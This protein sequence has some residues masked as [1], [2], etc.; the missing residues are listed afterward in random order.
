[1]E[2]IVFKKGRHRSRFRFPRFFWKQRLEFTGYFEKDCMYTPHNLGVHAY[3]SLPVNKLFG[4]SLG[5]NHHENSV[6]LGWRPLPYDKDEGR[7]IGLYA[8]Y[9]VNGKRTFELLSRVRV[10]EYFTAEI[11]ILSKTLVQVS[12]QV[13]VE[14]TVTVFVKFDGKHN[15][16]FNYRLFEYFGGERP[17]PH[18]ITIYKNK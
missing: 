1:M 5:G 14:S 13:G 11:Q 6:R 7:L 15:D 18:D 9:Y 17:T 3:A 2:K 8:Y 12:V 4:F 16:W 10:R